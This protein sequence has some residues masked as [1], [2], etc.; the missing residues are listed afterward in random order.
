MNASNISN[1]RAQILIERASGDASEWAPITSKAIGTS[2][3]MGSRWGYV[4][5]DVG[6][7]KVNILIRGSCR[8]RNASKTWEPF[9]ELISM[10]RRLLTSSE[11]F[12]KSKIREGLVLPFF[13]TKFSLASL[14][15]YCGCRGEILLTLGPP[16]LRK[17]WT[18]STS[19]QVLPSPLQNKKV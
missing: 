8:N 5:L 11:R 14:G 16:Q 12:E 1:H 2:M 13:L 3:P 15:D 17:W 4:G 10:T 18:F 7:Y 19:L 9:R 6:G